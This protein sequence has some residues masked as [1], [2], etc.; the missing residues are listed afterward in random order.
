MVKQPP[1]VKNK[2]QIDPC[3]LAP[4]MDSLSRKSATEN[5]PTTNPWEKTVQTWTSLATRDNHFPHTN[6]S[7]GQTQA[8]AQ[9][10]KAEETIITGSTSHKEPNPTNPSFK[11]NVHAP[12]FVPRSLPQTPISGYF[13]P[14]LQFLGNGVGD[15]IY[16]AE[17]NPSSF[18]A[19]SQARTAANTKGNN[20]VVQKIVKQVEYQFSDT[21]LIASDFLMKIMNKDP[22]GYGME[23]FI[24]TFLWWLVSSFIFFLLVLSWNSS[25]VCNCI[26]EEDKVSW[27]QPSNVDQISSNLDKACMSLL[28]LTTDLVTI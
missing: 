24:V 15:W 8:M 26:L 6:Q 7:Q 1:T 18:V 19:G 17:Q 21:N 20:D 10:K 9:E 3:L 4:N 22:E 16:F 2:K 12:E 13:Y 14:Y 27:Y 23:L 25:N 11:F 28:L 5:S